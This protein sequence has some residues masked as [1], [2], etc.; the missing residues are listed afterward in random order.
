MNDKIEEIAIIGMSGAFPGAK[1]INELWEMLITKRDGISTLT[2]DQLV[3]AG[4]KSEDIDNPS[5]V[6][7]YGFLDEAEFFDNDFF[8][9]TH[10]ESVTTDPQHRLLLSHSY[11]ALIDS[12]YASEQ[13]EVPVGVFAGQSAPKYWFYLKSGTVTQGLDDFRLMIGNDKDFLSTRVSYKLNLKGPSVNIQTGCSTSM[14]A[15]YYA[16]Q[17]LLTYGCDMALAGGVSVTAPRKKGYFYYDGMI[18]SKTG[19][20]RPF[21]EKADGAVFSEGVG[22]VCLK[23]LSEAVKDNDYIYAVIKNVSINNDGADKIGYT[24]PSVNGQ[25]EVIILAQAMAAVHPEDIGFIETHGTAT[26]LGDPVELKA[27]NAA[28][29][30]ETDK[31]GYC[32]LGSIKGNIGHLDAAAGVASLIKTALVVNTGVVP[33]MMNFKTPNPLLDIE[34][35]PFLIN[36]EPVIW[37][38][39]NG[40]RIAGVSS[41]GVGGTNI[42]AILESPPEKKKNT[43]KDLQAETVRLTAK[44]PD[45]LNALKSEIA[46]F[47]EK[48]SKVSEYDVISKI[49]KPDHD[50]PYRWGAYFHDRD[51]LVKKLKDTAGAGQISSDVKP[52]F[53]FPGQGSQFAGMA[54]SYYNVLPVFTEWI[55]K[56]I[57][58]SERLGLTKIRSFLL[59][60]G[61][62]SEI[63]ETEITQ[64]LLYILEYALSME[65]ISRGI[66]PYA[67]AGHSIGEYTAA[68]V[69][70]VMSFEDGLMLVIRRGYWMQRAAEGAM[71]AVTILSADITPYLHDGISISLYNTENQVVLSGKESDIMVLE[72]KLVSD[73]V[74]FKRLKTSHAFHSPL[75]NE[76]IDNFS[77]DVQ[78][79]NFNNAEI[80]FLSNIGGE[81]I[82]ESINWAEYW[83]KQLREPVRFDLCIKSLTGLKGSVMIETGPGRVLTGFINSSVD[84][85]AESYPLLVNSEADKGYFISSLIS[86]WERGIP[87]IFNEVRISPDSLV[88]SP[89]YAFQKKRFWPELTMR[90]EDVKTGNNIL[91]DT[92]GNGFSVKDK[93]LSTREEVLKI[94][95]QVLGCTEVM[96]HDNFFE[97]GGDSLTSVQFVQAVKSLFKIDFS[98]PFFLKNPTPEGIIN[99]IDEVLRTK[100]ESLIQSN[101]LTIK[102]RGLTSPVQLSP[103]QE[104]LW[105]LHEL[106][107]DKPLYNIVHVLRLEGEYDNSILTESLKSFFKRH[108]L[109]R[110]YINSDSD[111]PELAFVKEAA[112]PVEIVDYN[113]KDIDEAGKSY[114]QFLKNE[115]VKPADFTQYPIIKV[116]I[117]RFFDDLC[118]I[119]LF[120]PHIFTDGWSSEIFLNEIKEIYSRI[121]DGR[122]ELPPLPIQ[123]SDYAV[124][125]VEQK[126]KRI[127]SG[128]LTGFWKEYLKNIPGVH[129][130]PLDFPRPKEMSGYGGVVNFSLGDEVS[131]GVRRVCSENHITPNVFFLAA[132]A[133]LIWKYSSQQTVV[134]GTPYANREHQELMSI[135]GYFIRT[136]PLRLDVEPSKDVREWLSYVKEQFLSAWSM[137]GLGIDELVD[138]IEVQRI[139]N[140]NPVYQVL[141]AYQSYHRGSVKDGVTRFSQEFPDRGISENDLA[142]YMWDNDGFAGSLEYSTDIFIKS[143]IGLFAENFKTL[144]MRLTENKERIPGEKISMIRILSPQDEDKILREWNNTRREYDFSIPLHR[145]FERQAEKTPGRVALRFMEKSLS[146]GELN[147][148]ANMLAYKLIEAGVAPDSI[149]GVYMERSIEMVVSLYAIIKAGGA[150]L[151]LNPELPEARIKFITEDAEPVLILTQKHLEK[152]I[153]EC[154]ATILPIDPD[155]EVISDYNCDNPYSPV[156][157]EN[158]AYCIYTSGSTGNPKGALIS[159]KSICNRLIWMQEYFNINENDRILQKTP[160]DFDVSVWEF[161]WP[162]ICGASLVIA[163]AGGHRDTKY[164][165]HLISSEGITVIHFVP[166][167]L[168]IFLNDPE[169]SGCRT[170]RYVI[171]SGEALPY[172]LQDRFFRIFNCGLY[173]L[174]GPTEAA[175][176][177]TY[178]KCS[179]DYERKIVP[180]GYPVANTS[181][182]ILDS[183]MSPVPPGV[184][185]DL[186]IG[187][188]QLARGYLNR[189]ELTREKFIADPFS[190]EP[191]SRLYKTGDIA[192]WMPDGAIEYLGRSDFQIKFNGIRIETGEIEYGICRHPSISGAVVV[193]HKKGDKKKLAA[194]YTLKPGESCSALEIRDKLKEYLPAPVVPS[195]FVEM[196]SFPKT[197]SGKVDRKMLPAPEETGLGDEERLIAFPQTNLEMKMHEIWRDVLEIDSFGINDNFFDLGGHSL[198]AAVLVRKMNDSLGNKWQLRDI[199][200]FPTIEGLAA[201]VKERIVSS[202]ASTIIPRRE[203]NVPVPLSPQQERLW[204]LHELEPEKPLYNVLHVLRVEGDYNQVFLRE[205]VK[206]FLERHD[207]FRAYID[208]L[209]DKPHLLFAAETAIPFEDISFASGSPDEAEEKFNGLIKEEL[210]KPLNFKRYPFIN[211]KF[212]VFRNDLCRICLFVPHIFTDGWSSEILLDEIKEI[213]HRIAE[214]KDALPPLQIKYSDY[215]AW[216]LEQKEKRIISEDL[217]GFW[218]D[219]LKGI[220]EVHEIPLDFP[221]PREMS[222]YGGVVDFSLGDEISVGVK[223]VC[224]ENHVTPNVFFLSAFAI[225]IWKYSSQETVVIGTP[226]ANREL[227]ELKGIFGYF[228]RTIPLRFDIDPAK[229]LNAWYSYVREQFLSAWSMSGLG[230]DELVDIIEVPRTMNINPLIQVVFAYQSYSKGQRALNGLRFSQEFPERG[231]SEN[232]LALYMWEGEGFSG[233]IEFSG[234]IFEKNSIELFI[235]NFKALIYNFI[236]EP[237]LSLDETS[238]LGHEQ[239]DFIKDINSTEKNSHIGLTFIDLFRE[240]CIKYSDRTALWFSGR[241][242]TYS[243]IDKLSD[244]IAELLGSSGVRQG[245]FIA[246]YLN[247]GPMFLSSL[248]GVM[249]AGC[250]YVP[251][252]PYFPDERLKQIIDDSGIDYVVSEYGFAG[253]TL[254]KGITSSVIF[255]DGQNSP[256]VNGSHPIINPGDHAYML[257][258]SGSTG[259]PKGVPITHGAMANLLLTLR[260]NMQIDSSDRFLASTTPSFDISVAEMF[261]PLISGASQVMVTSEEAMDGR[262]LSD[263]IDKEKITFVQATPTGWMFLFESGWKGKKGL[264]I[265]TGGETL[266]RE[267]AGRLLET[268]AKVFLGYGPTETT[269][270][271]SLSIVDKHDREPLIGKPVANTMFYVLDKRNRILPPGIPGELAIGGAG[272]STGYY[273][274]PELNDEK[275]IDL[276]IPDKTGLEKVY[277]TGDLVILTHSGEYRYLGRTDFQVKIRGFRIEPGEIESI[278]QKYDGII[279]A[280]CN[281]WKHSGTDKHLVAYYRSSSVIDEEDLKKHLRIHLPD[282]MIPGYLIRLD[283]FPKTGSGKTDRQGFPLPNYRDTS[284]ETRIIVHPRTQLEQKIFEIWSEVLER[285]GFG[286]RDSF[287]N[288]GGHSILAASLIRKMNE[289]LGTNWQLRDLFEV[290][291]IEGL[292]GMIKTKTGDMPLLF[293]VQKKGSKKPF[294]LVAGVYNNRYYDGD[295]ITEYEKDFLKYFSNILVMIGEEHPV[296]GLRPRGILKGEQFHANVSEIAADYIREIK[297]IQSEGPYIIGGECLGGNIAYEIAVQLKRNGEVVS[298]LILLDSYRITSSYEL[299]SRLIFNYRFLRNSIKDIAGLRTESAPDDRKLTEKIRDLRKTFF[300]FNNAEKEFSRL[301]RGSLKYASILIKYRPVRY[302]GKVILII[303]EEWNNITPLLQ[304]N[305]K[306]C[307][308]LTVRVVPGNHITRLKNPGHILKQALLENI[309]VV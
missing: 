224:S 300:P 251:L 130:I 65:L 226:Y 98:I 199:F 172:S 165:A 237:L 62:E 161:F 280:V 48:N 15:I 58:Y 282:Y 73:S 128:E 263:V 49:M 112:I 268:G 259:R 125:E 8:G 14:T 5:Y 293:P 284:V 54:K 286:I 120:V 217:T 227:D 183:S 18:F 182:Y 135:F 1:N 3:D 257:F 50:Y 107:P 235:N 288:L 35:S 111:T 193:L 305:S 42:H 180:I 33:P 197:S 4:E 225:L 287:F 100:Q 186:Y 10:S 121:R 223:R 96:L 258:T 175:V 154:A 229:N 109:F 207:L 196:K 136:I 75:M 17:S 302:D 139:M 77:K 272:L 25:R 69:A 195:Y 102:P 163:D 273:N 189:D 194:Y 138:I 156:S 201:A 104:R 166:A 191:G 281:V 152:N 215:A 271:S 142:L 51:S 208:I 32:Y 213:Y 238:L 7:R 114:N 240:A 52:V 275:F 285:E 84:I 153:P 283:S 234:D 270:I 266:T 290:P 230:I 30:R 99:F 44:S 133:M 66:K 176:D 140:V 134:I 41:F 173:N 59:E 179:M 203:G 244:E 150:Y 210:K 278:L 206:I 11:L 236:K 296:Y 113:G 88:L 188:V 214:C 198:L 187:G 81:W 145:L 243:E 158:L 132:F 103:Q 110:A 222:G 22:V 21:D 279:E 151:P 63:S 34:K 209:N 89:V 31:K 245:E 39:I 178:W 141:F 295:G 306:I 261:L 308:N 64:P 155:F 289:R 256:V 239:L 292:A 37:N 60:D 6:P 72:K 71:T 170:L 101:E 185:G 129:E 219:Y 79:V 45:S 16:C 147:N 143:S 116:T 43:N 82:D 23:R 233:S 260:E 249:K 247:R 46:S 212:C 304:W 26:Q 164:L 40:I 115:S 168:E 242:W 47:L 277:K 265:L 95:K 181:M 169:I 126:E 9:M 171:C 216:E 61:F 70:G 123:Y 303:N 144:I 87:V 157:C 55:D 298:S 184:V 252:D 119:C 211:V 204:F 137:S 294:F 94:W 167:M 231:I 246:V 232:D 74:P 93:P 200:E 53:I 57:L 78:K 97:S 127:I 267:L 228:I 131:A 106:E 301:E 221:R 19:F 291:T 108:E 274:R 190:A 160:F 117:F 248:I 250:A 29:R 13:F 2:R 80:P 297:Q 159:H 83:T 262:R 241:N 174:Y 220:P 122:D 118:R 85:A 12:G 24:A 299:T 202:G 177:V 218:R 90:A 205:S 309:D 91:T 192:R 28:F 86:L 56:G 124:W 105:F 67:V 162:L 148:K 253:S 307:P 92:I 276:Y 76:I 38:T 269:V 255:V 36:Q 149:V 20:C 68:A 27:L 146:Y 264:K 254:L